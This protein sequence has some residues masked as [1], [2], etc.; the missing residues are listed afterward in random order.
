MD[1]KYKAVCGRTRRRGRHTVSNFIGPV[2]VEKNEKI[3]KE[4]QHSGV[5]RKWQNTVRRKR[6]LMRRRGFDY[7][8]LTQHGQG[9]A[10]RISVE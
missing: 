7:C 4:N 3:E 10:V 2:S 5:D 8:L 6:K 1:S 9:R